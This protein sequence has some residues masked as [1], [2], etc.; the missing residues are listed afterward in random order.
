MLEKYPDRGVLYP[1]NG[2]RRLFSLLMDKNDLYKRIKIA[3]MISFIPVV[4]VG[5]VFSGYIGGVLLRDKFAIGD[6]AVLIGIGVG[7]AAG[8]FEVI[9]II[10]KVLSIDNGP[11]NS[12][13]D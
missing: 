4:L 12:S 1:I 5:S 11:K 6:N 8:I 2:Y 13:T 3:G 10:R 9:R 7:V